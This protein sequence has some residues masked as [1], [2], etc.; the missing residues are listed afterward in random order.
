MPPSLQARAPAVL[1]TTPTVSKLVPVRVL[2]PLLALSLID[3]VAVD[4]HATVNP[5]A[6]VAQ[7]VVL[8]RAVDCRASAPVEGRA[9]RRPDAAGRSRS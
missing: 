6:R 1:Q 2:M 8:V 3:V 5:N 7:G 9:E 4:R